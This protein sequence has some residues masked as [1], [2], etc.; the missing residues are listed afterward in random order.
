MHANIF[1]KNTFVRRWVDL[2][3]QL[4]LATTM[5]AKKRKAAKKTAKKKTAK[6]RR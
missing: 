2:S 1:Y 5:A 4:N 3:A 6:R